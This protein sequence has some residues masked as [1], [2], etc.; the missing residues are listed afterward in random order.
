[1]AN[2]WGK[3][4]AS[5]PT[6]TT[7][8]TANATKAGTQTYQ[9]RVVTSAA[10]NL[11]VGDSSTTSTAWLFVPIVAVTI[12]EYFAVTPGQYYLP[13]AGMSVTEMS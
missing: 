3:Q 13:C 12:G 2:Y 8:T 7:T 11:G 1:M 4:L 10:G 5:R 6:L 9:L